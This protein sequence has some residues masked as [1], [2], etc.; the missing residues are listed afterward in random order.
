[1]P[2]T[3]WSCG[4]PPDELELELLD[5]DDDDSPLDEPP[6]DDEPPLD[7]ADLPSPQKELFVSAQAVVT[8][9]QEPSTH[10]A[11]A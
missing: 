11:A 6:P 5:E 8:S 1:L 10:A 7:D 9:A 3:H 2:S 4:P